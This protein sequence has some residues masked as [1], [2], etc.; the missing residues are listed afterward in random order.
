VHA[1]AYPLGS[2]FH[3]PHGLSNSLVLGPVLRFNSLRCETQYAELADVILPGY[4]GGVAEKA[5]AF[6]QAMAEVAG[7]LELPTRLAQVGVTAADIPAL[8]GL[9]LQQQRLLGNNPRDV[10]LADAT[11]LYEE[12]F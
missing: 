8:A 5:A 9:A 10:T 11:R 6:V 7:A 12:A 2:A 1:L 4:A 3:V